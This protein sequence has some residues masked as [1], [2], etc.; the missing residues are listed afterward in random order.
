LEKV[1]LHKLCQPKSNHVNFPVVPENSTRAGITRGIPVME[2]EQE[3][4]GINMKSKTEC[5]ATRAQVEEAK[6][7]GRVDVDRMKSGVRQQI[8]TSSAV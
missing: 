1:Q 2:A 5:D 3:R 4:V 6:P 8:L 7:H